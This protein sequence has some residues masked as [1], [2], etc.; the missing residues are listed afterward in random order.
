MTLE[1]LFCCPRLLCVLVVLLRWL[2]GVELLVFTEGVDLCDVIGAVDEDVEV[3][4]VGE[5]A[6]GDVDEDDDVF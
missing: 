4:V 3:W 6:C 2:W 1:L 5:D